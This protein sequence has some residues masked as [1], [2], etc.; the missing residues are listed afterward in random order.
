[1]ILS[2]FDV[3]IFFWKDRPQSEGRRHAHP[4]IKTEPEREMVHTRHGG[5]SR[6]QIAIRR[7]FSIERELVPRGRST[8]V[9]AGSDNT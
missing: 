6:V 1:M 2:G 7:A 5:G 4:G 8:W 3:I 9:V